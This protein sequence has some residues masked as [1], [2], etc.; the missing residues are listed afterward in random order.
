MTDPWQQTPYPAADADPQR[1]VS[2][3]EVVEVVITATG[4]RQCWTGQT[5]NAHLDAAR[6]QQRAPLG[7]LAPNA[8]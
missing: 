5:W 4:D 2:P 7:Q 6:R 8:A 1:Y 3:L